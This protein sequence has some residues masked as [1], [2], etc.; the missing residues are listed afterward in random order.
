MPKII[1][2]T[3]SKAMTK[4]D[5]AA[6]RRI[7]SSV[8]IAVLKEKTGLSELEIISRVKGAGEKTRAFLADLNQ[9]FKGGA[10]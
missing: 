2:R 10:K 4:E 8:T 5:I 6:A 9:L 1:K 7:L 3:K